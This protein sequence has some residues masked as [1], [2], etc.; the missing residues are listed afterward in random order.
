LNCQND[1]GPLDILGEI[2]K[3][4]EAA[5]S[6]VGTAMEGVTTVMSLVP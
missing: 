5:A 1:A 3:A 4:V 6:A 2:C